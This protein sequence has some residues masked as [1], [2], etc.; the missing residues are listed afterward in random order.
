M[1]RNNIRILQIF[2]VVIA[3]RAIVKRSNA[4]LYYINNLDRSCMSEPRLNVLILTYVHG[5]LE[6]NYE[7]H[8]FLEKHQR[9]LLLILPTV[10]D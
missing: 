8:S 4:A 1:F 10:A 6:L 5:H 3:T 9:K 7:K 2:L